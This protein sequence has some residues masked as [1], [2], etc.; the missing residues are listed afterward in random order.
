MSVCKIGRIGPTHPA[1]LYIIAFRWNLLYIYM[2][3]ESPSLGVNNRTYQTL[4]NALVKDRQ[5]ESTRLL[6]CYKDCKKRFFL[7][8]KIVEAETGSFL[9][10][11]AGCWETFTFSDKR[12]TKARE[13]LL[14]YLR[15]K[16]P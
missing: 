4:L 9:S 12:K 15:K 1:H 3:R 7:Q 16:L 13:Y 11:S 8:E 14:R 5:K 6:S 10:N 2:Y